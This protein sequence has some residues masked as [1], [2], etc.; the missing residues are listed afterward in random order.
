MR[1]IRMIQVNFAANGPLKEK[2]CAGGGQVYMVLLERQVQKVELNG[3]KDAD[4]RGKFTNQVS[5]VAKG[6]HQKNLTH[7][8]KLVRLEGSQSGEEGR[9]RPIANLG[10]GTLSGREKGNG[11]IGLGPN[12]LERA[13]EG[14]GAEIR[15]SKRFK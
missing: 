3:L 12:S 5:K 2:K 1:T 4:E 7:R 10:G 6:R 11:G 15:K 13:Q 9:Y 14:L 8:R